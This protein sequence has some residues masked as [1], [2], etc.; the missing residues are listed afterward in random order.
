MGIGSTIRIR[1]LGIRQLTARRVL[2][3]LVL[4]LAAA[5]SL[6]VGLAVS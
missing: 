1:E 2:A 3:D 4:G 6:Q 5:I